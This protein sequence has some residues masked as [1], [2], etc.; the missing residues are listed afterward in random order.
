V[1]TLV[2][3]EAQ[4]LYTLALDEDLLAEGPVRLQRGD[5]TLGILISPQEYEAF[6]VW[7]EEQ[8]QGVEDWPAPFEVIAFPEPYVLLGRDVLND[9][10]VQLNGPE[11]TFDLSLDNPES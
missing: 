5:E 9:F 2:L 7:R 6:R 4:P 10:C 1:K 11:L 3:K 8:R